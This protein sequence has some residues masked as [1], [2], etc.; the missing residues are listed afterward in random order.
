MNFSKPTEELLECLDILMA[1]VERRQAWR[2]YEEMC[3]AFDDFYTSELP[4]TGQGAPAGWWNTSDWGASDMA[5]E[6]E[7][8]EEVLYSLKP[9][10]LADEVVETAMW[11]AGELALGLLV[12]HMHALDEIHAYEDEALARLQADKRAPKIYLAD[13]SAHTVEDQ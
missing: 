7:A 9:K 3:Y 2:E 12:E 4:R 6:Y 8:Q 1:E 13:G 10:P 5:E 11:Q